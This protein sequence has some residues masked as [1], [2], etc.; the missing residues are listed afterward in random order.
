MPTPM[1][2]IGEWA[3]SLPLRP[4]VNSKKILSTTQKTLSSNERNRPAPTL[5]RD[6]RFL[7]ELEGRYRELL[8]NDLTQRGEPTKTWKVNGLEDAYW[9]VKYYDHVLRSDGEITEESE[10]DTNEFHRA[11]LN[12]LSKLARLIM[13]QKAAEITGQTDIQCDMLVY[14]P[15]VESQKALDDGADKRVAIPDHIF[16]GSIGDERS[17]ELKLV[18]IED[19]NTAFGSAHG[20]AVDN[21]VGHTQSVSLSAG[22]PPEERVWRQVSG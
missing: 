15:T 8:E 11:I 9:S 2:L 1:Y 16:I 6:S 21:R 22:I 18:C 19:K 10:S 20:S 14:K 17:R 12:P 3:K 13:V 4:L 7:D 5:V